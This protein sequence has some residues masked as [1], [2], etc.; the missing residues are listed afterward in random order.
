MFKTFDTV[1]L[2]LVL[3][4]AFW[5]DSTVVVQEQIRISGRDFPRTFPRSREGEHP[6][7]LLIAAISMCALALAPR[8][9]TPADSSEPDQ[10]PLAKR[11]LLRR[12]KRQWFP[13][14]GRLV[15]NVKKLGRSDGGWEEG[16]GEERSLRNSKD[17]PYL[18][19][20]RK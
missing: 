4:V 10:R 6:G 9:V 13:R 5:Y 17:C 2:V 20:D 16:K 11:S 3:A 19:E 7:S 15:Q 8:G 12:S 14:L 1:P 18:T